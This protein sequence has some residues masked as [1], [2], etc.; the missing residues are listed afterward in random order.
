[1]GS[2]RELLVDHNARGGMWCLEVGAVCNWRYNNDS[3]AFYQNRLQ[4]LA[5]SR[6]TDTVLMLL[7]AYGERDLRAACRTNI[8][9]EHNGNSSTI[10]PSSSEYRIKGSGHHL[11][12]LRFP[13][14]AFKPCA[15]TVNLYFVYNGGDFRGTDYE[16]VKFL[17]L[18][19]DRDARELFTGGHNGSAAPLPWGARQR[20]R[21]PL[22]LP[23][24][25]RACG[26]ESWNLP[27]G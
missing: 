15:T 20:H 1:M 5:F 6:D 13:L 4:K 10:S 27:A 11:C 8:V 18:S 9:R 17:E 22:S 25:S 12:V 16:C 7:D 19:N 23:Y 14:D 3:G 26:P 21:L 2:W 24:D